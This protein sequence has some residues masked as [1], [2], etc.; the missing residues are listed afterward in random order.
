MEYIT[1]TAAETQKIGERLS[2]S[3]KGGEIIALKGA[4]GAGKTTFIQG[5]ARG[6]GIKKRIIS[7]TFIIVRTYRVGKINF[8][9]V[10]LYRLEGNLER[11]IENLGLKDFWGRPENITVIEWAEK[12]KR[13]L[14]PGTIWI[15]FKYLSQD[16]RQIT[17]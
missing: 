17:W 6:L 1:K 11:E 13:H 12:I 10:D 15:K 2:A 3:L 5:I 8:Y 9:H 4:L 14:P 7:P 16:K